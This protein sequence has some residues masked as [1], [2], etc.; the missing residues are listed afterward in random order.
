M[1]EPHGRP[2]FIAVNILG[3][4]LFV[5]TLAFYF[6]TTLFDCTICPNFNAFWLGIMVFIKSW[7]EY[8]AQAEKLYEQQPERVCIPD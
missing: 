4:G 3:F 5:V 2:I 8:Q 6:D 7:S 1:S